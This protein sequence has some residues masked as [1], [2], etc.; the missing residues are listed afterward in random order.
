MAMGI[1]KMGIIELMMWMV[2]PVMISRL[3]VDKAQTTATIMGEVMKI[4]RLKNHH[5][6]KKMTNIASGA[7]IAIC[8]NISTPKVSSATGNP[9]I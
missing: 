9:V 1:M 5:N 7:E 8:L 4:S 6:N 3:I 2:L